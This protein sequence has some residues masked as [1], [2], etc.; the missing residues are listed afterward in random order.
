VSG[1]C[2][3]CGS[4]LGASAKFCA[5][6]GAEAGS[7]KASQGATTSQVKPPKAKKPH[8]G[9]KIL[10]VIVFFFVV[11]GIIAAATDSNNASSTSGPS[12]SAASSGNPGVPQ[13]EKDARA[14]IRDLGFDA[15]KVEA[16]VGLVQI[17][18]GFTIKSPTAANIDKLAQYAQ[19]A[20]DNIDG[21]RAD[22]ANTNEDG[23]GLGDAELSAFSGA[24]DLKNA[25]GALVAYTGD[26]NAATLASFTTQY[27]KARG[28]WDYGVRTIWRV[29]QKKHPPK[30]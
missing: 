1:F 5:A 11:I 14:W 19:Q 28:E 8:R 10:S 16:N 26:P 30:I 25:M 17:Q 13:N 27:Q 7:A 2:E 24:N 3:Q 20:H 23:G 9:L 12:A 29:A 21:I 18:L 4:A 22:F 6:C 15:G